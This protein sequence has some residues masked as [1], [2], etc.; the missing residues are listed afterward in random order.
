MLEVFRK[1]RKSML[2]KQVQYFL[3]ANRLANEI[4]IQVN[5]ANPWLKKVKISSNVAMLLAG[6]FYYEGMS[7]ENIW[8]LL[9]SEVLFIGS[10]EACL[11]V[12]LWYIANWRVFYFNLHW[13]ATL[14]AF[15][16]SI[17]K[18]VAQ[19]T[20]SVIGTGVMNTYCDFSVIK[21]TGRVHRGEITPSEFQ[22]NFKKKVWNAPMAAQPWDTPTTDSKVTPCLEGPEK[23]K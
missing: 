2:P 10:L 4:I 11:A 21:E 5:L 9:L 13:T 18:P 1:K 3:E 17:G 14:L 6:I 19:T 8:L 22:D 20:G 15:G 23:K 16:K 12:I 7:H